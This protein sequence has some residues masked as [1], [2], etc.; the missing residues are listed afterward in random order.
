MNDQPPRRLA[1]HF[2]VFIEDQVAAGHFDSPDIRDGRGTRL[3]ERREAREAALAAALREGSKA[4]KPSISTW[5]PG[6]MNKTGSIAKRE[7]HPSQ[8][9]GVRGHSRDQ[10]I[11]E[12]GL[13]AGTSPKLF[14][15]TQR[16]IP[17]HRRRLGP[18]RN[19]QC[20][21]SIIQALPISGASDLFRRDVKRGRDCARA[22]PR[23]E[24]RC[25]TKRKLI[26]H[27]TQSSPI[28]R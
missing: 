24:Y 9:E 1:R 6:W 28:S 8:A 22:A 23:D 12:K 7:T 16:P 17:S 5:S 20:G 26:R 11:D 14:E 21:R 27:S 3:L 15:R 2:E 19:R 18:R 10:A 4:A 25:T 13:G